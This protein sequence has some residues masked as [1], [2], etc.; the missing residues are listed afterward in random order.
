MNAVMPLDAL[1]TTAAPRDALPANATPRDAL[2][3]APV[4]FDGLWL[5]MITPL[6]QGRVDLYAAQALARRY[7]DAGLAGLVLFGSTGEG[8]LLSIAEKCEVLDAVRGDAN[9]LPVVIGAG[10]IDTRSVTALIRRFERA[11]PAAYLVPPPA[12]LRPS[13]AGIVWHYHQI[14]WTTE[15]PIILYNIPERTGVALTV[16]TMETLARDPQYA[17]V[18]EC[19]PGLLAA[20]N[21]RGRV[22]ALCG[23]D[24]MLMDHFLAGGTGAIPAAAHLFPE[25]F[26]AMMRAARAGD[27]PRAE[28]LFAPLRKLIRLLFSEPNPAPL[29]RALSMQG[30]IVDELRQPLMPASAELTAKLERTLAQAAEPPAQLPAA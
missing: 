13:Q 20:L 12:Y 23:A 11:A 7:R 15:R 18:K 8:S 9:A 10:G 30:L 19:H 2:P 14:A 29:K 3:D 17:A 22:Q 26:V 27:A 6:R 4:R 5:P 1:S 28:A 21:Q 25:R 24:A 16:D